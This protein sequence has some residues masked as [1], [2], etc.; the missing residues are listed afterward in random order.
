MLDKE[1]KIV[2]TEAAAHC[3]QRPHVSALWRW[4]RKGL[5][6]AG[7]GRVRLE[8]VRIGGRIYTSRQA[9]ERFFAAVAAADLE[10][11]RDDDATFAHEV[12]PSSAQRE[13]E[14]AA[15]DK[16]LASAGI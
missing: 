6:T 1:K 7:G 15:A 4:C 2:F 10:Y 12:E 14:I 8:H 13:R 9:M 5:K 3:P 16:R 11:F